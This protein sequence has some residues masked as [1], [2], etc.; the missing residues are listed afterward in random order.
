M[1]YANT[2]SLLYIQTGSQ[3]TG[4]YS[5]ELKSLGIIQ[6][7][8]MNSERSDCFRTT[9]FLSCFC[10]EMIW[11]GHYTASDLILK[12]D[13]QCCAGA[14]KC[15]NPKV[16]T[17]AGDCSWIYIRRK[18]ERD[19][20]TWES[21]LEGFFVR[22]REVFLLHVW[23]CVQ[24]QNWNQELDQCRGQMHTEDL[25]DVIA[26]VIHCCMHHVT[27]NPYSDVY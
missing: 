13:M 10:P 12:H 19:L 11:K 3:S 2:Q 27:R 21:G 4:Y 24:Y 6:W 1:K 22:K 14:T 15:F 5:P 8:N 18:S 25:W 20:F 9:F 23:S 16:T 7:W 26:W 17:R